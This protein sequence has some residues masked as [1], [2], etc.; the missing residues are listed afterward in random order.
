MAMGM[1]GRNRYLRR[2]IASLEMALVIPVMVLF[3]AAI[4]EY[5][6]LFLAGQ[7]GASAARHGARAASLP[8]ATAEDVHASME[9]YLQRRALHEVA[10][11]T[12]DPADPSE[13]ASGEPVTVRVE[14]DYTQRRVMRIV[15]T[16]GKLVSETT[17]AKEGP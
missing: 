6:L 10:T 1:R 5:G 15:P 3:F 4:I 2:G 16:P 9:N 14:I 11:L 7:D 17:M 8:D 13:A 12:M